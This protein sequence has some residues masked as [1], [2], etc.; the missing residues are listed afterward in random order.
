MNGGYFGETLCFDT[1]LRY[2]FIVCIVNCC[3][4]TGTLQ[5][6]EQLCITSAARD[7]TGMCAASAVR[8]LWL[9]LIQFQQQILLG[10]NRPASCRIGRGCP[11]RVCGC[12]S[13]H[14]VAHPDHAQAYSPL[15][16]PSHLPPTSSRQL[17]GRT[18]NKR[19]NRAASHRTTSPRCS[20]PASAQLPA[21]RHRPHRNASALAARPRP[22]RPN[23][24]AHT[25]PTH[26]RP[27]SH[28]PAAS[29]SNRCSTTPPSWVMTYVHSSSS[30]RGK[31]TA[32]TPALG[33][34]GMYRSPHRVYAPSP[35]AAAAR[36]AKRGS[37]TSRTAA[38]QS[39]SAAPPSPAPPTARE[40][41]DPGATGPDTT[42]PLPPPAPQPPPRQSCPLIVASM[43]H[44]PSSRQS[45][46][47]RSPLPCNATRR[48]WYPNAAQ[49]IQRPP[50]HPAINAPP[51][52]P[53]L[54][55]ATA[56]DHPPA[57]PTPR[58]LQ[59]KFARVE[60][61]QTVVVHTTKAKPQTADRT[62]L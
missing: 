23:R 46:V 38:C 24:N 26:D 47:H 44:R 34:T 18:A 22:P 56:A 13:S 61:I 62:T 27:T 48:R 1:S 29:S 3:V 59:R 16:T 39:S 12:S 41:E 50:T 2:H 17:Q 6:R 60:R 11:R 32:S 31:A 14:L 43:S 28:P 5:G 37:H 21:H 54:N 40:F 35:S 52:T 42:S 20:L 8:H 33:R 58:T 4:D 49:R 15:S 19:F 7:C 25:R 57:A 10:R 36:A 51:L 30:Y 45:P 53:L 9:S 55:V